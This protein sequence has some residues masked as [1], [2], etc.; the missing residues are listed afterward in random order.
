[1]SVFYKNENKKIN[2]M[3]IFSEMENLKLLHYYKSPFGLKIVIEM[4]YSLKLLNT[5][6]MIFIIILNSNQIYPSK[7]SSNR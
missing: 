4:I 7:N 2:L 5:L 1:M 6:L 3:S